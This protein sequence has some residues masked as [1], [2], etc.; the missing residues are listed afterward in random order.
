MSCQV[1]EELFRIIL[2]D[3]WV[4]GYREGAS[5]YSLR[6]ATNPMLSISRQPV[7]EKGVARVHLS[8]DLLEVCIFG[9]PPFGSRARSES[10][11]P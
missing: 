7:E 1:V 8:S 6:I 9:N 2:C 5:P 3:G 11:H 4:V 10:R